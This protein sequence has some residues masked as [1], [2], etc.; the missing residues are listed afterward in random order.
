MT[1]KVHSLN[2]GKVQVI[3]GS[4]KKEVASGIIKRPVEGSVFLT[5]VG[6][7]GDEQQDLVHHGGVDKAVCVYPAEHYPYW[8]EKL[9][10][11]I[12]AGAFGENVTVSGLVET[13][14]CIGDTFE[15]GEAVVQVSQPRHPCY[16]LAKRHDVKELPLFVQETGYSGFYFRVLQEGHVSAEDHLRLKERHTEMTIARVNR[17]NFQDADDVEGLKQLAELPYLAES[18]REGVEKKLGKVM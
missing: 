18:W 8:H 4:G 14:V 7:K 15:W 6:L 9:G 16:K 10:K 17:L 2:T 5:S 12:D 13:D 1:G 3:A 11:E